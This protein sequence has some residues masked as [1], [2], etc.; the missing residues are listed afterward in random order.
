VI[1]LAAVALALTGCVLK[2]KP[3]TTA[4]AIPAPKPVPP[5]APPPAPPA[6]LSIPQT[7]VDL[8]APQT[9]SQEAMASAEPPGTPPPPAPKPPTKKGTTPT[10]VVAAPKPEVA[11]PAPPTPA[12]TPPAE[13]ER[14]PIQDIL[15]P[16]EV[17][18]LKTGIDNFRNAIRQALERLPQRN[19]LNKR[20][21][22]AVDTINTFTR[23]CDDAVNSG[24]LRKA[25]GLAERGAV[26]AQGLQS[27][28]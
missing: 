10:P 19:R 17:N 9:I 4:A 13:S 24:D 15:P 11:P 12:A 25:Y 2:G 22:D 28:R 1:L 7:H 26:L 23:L 5:P 21:R 27:V 6:P 20:E 8:P 3:A 14:P 16:D 18:R